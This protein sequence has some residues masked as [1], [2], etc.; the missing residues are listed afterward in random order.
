MKIHI[1]KAGET[2]WKIA[3][4]YKL[5]VSELISFNPQ[6]ANPD[7]LKTG[8]KVKVPKSAV[9]VSP[10]AKK[11]KPESN[12][13]PHGIPG[14]DE[15]E[16]APAEDGA[17]PIPLKPMPSVPVEGTPKPM[18]MPMPGSSPG[19]PYEMPM[20]PHQGMMNYPPLAMNHA[21][22]MQPPWMM[23]H[24]MMMQPEQ[25]MAPGMMMNHEQMLAYEAWLRGYGA[26][27]LD[28][29][30]MPMHG[31]YPQAPY[32]QHGWGDGMNRG[33]HQPNSLPKDETK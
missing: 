27:Y 10:K 9:S 24:G 31:F 22:M 5:D 7:Q 12:P 28:P 6:I 3:Q 16:L 33:F 8:S 18:E 25:M 26:P 30:M 19:M 20:M 21:P 11:V 15:T 32:P 1:V 4:K 23:G 17:I 13:A 2:L 29:M 14:Y